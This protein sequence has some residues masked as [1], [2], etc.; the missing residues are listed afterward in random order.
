MNSSFEFYVIL[1]VNFLF[2]LALEGFHSH[3]VLLIMFSFIFCLIESLKG[4][5]IYLC[6]V[7]SQWSEWPFQGTTLTL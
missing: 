4:F 6:F 7:L 1:S 2:I 3:T 5:N